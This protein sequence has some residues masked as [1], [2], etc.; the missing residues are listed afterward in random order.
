MGSAASSSPLL[1]SAE[2]AALAAPRCTARSA[3][4]ASRVRDRAGRSA[5]NSA[6]RYG[7]PPPRSSGF[8]T[9]AVARES[10]TKLPAT[11]ASSGGAG[12]TAGP[13]AVAAFPPRPMGAEAASDHAGAAASSDAKLDAEAAST[14]TSG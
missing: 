3:L 9:R 12:S 6:A 13:L 11:H 14:R 7:A 10:A 1:S 8:R 2:A 4:G 5:C